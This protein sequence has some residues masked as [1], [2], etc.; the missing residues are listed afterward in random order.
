MPWQLT[1]F[2]EDGARRPAYRLRF[3]S[4]LEL[5]ESTARAIILGYQLCAKYCAACLLDGLATSS[6]DDKVGVFIAI[7]HCATGFEVVRES[8]GFGVP[9]GPHFV[10]PKR[11]GKFP[12]REF[13]MRAISHILWVIKNVS[14]VCLCD[15]YSHFRRELVYASVSNNCI[16]FFV[17]FHVTLIA[18]I[19]V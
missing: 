4:I 5:R 16:R 15:K 17:Y 14:K 1:H 12:G 18:N 10:P 19:A 8:A 7:H 9:G 3:C 2:A 13:V 11:I 6:F